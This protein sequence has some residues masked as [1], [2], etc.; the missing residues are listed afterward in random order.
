MEVVK[1]QLKN[2][3]ERFLSITDKKKLTFEFPFLLFSTHHTV[4]DKVIS[5]FRHST[6]N[7]LKIKSYYNYTVLKTKVLIFVIN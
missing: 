5:V 7:S 1:E 4:E 2:I 6:S 3:E